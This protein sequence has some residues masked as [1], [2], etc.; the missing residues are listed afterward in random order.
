[1]TMRGSSTELRGIQFSAVRTEE[2]D[3]C[4]NVEPAHPVGTSSISQLIFNYT[5][6]IVGSGKQ[7]ACCVVMIHQNSVWKASLDFHSRSN[8]LG[9]GW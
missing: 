5:N 1:M 8:K 7:P 3:S 2:C 4:V 9:F 6:T